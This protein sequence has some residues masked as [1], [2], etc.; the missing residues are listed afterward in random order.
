MTNN[1][2]AKKKKI[3]LG[4]SAPLYASNFTHERDC[5]SQ[6]CG[7]VLIRVVEKTAPLL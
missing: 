6:L 5:V 2:I 1:C 3:K 7:F 4:Q